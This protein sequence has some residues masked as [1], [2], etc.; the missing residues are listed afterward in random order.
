MSWRNVVWLILFVC[1]GISCCSLLVVAQED[2]PGFDSFRDGVNPALETPKPVAPPRPK[3]AA[4]KLSEEPVVTEAEF[5]RRLDQVVSVDFEELELKEVVRQFEEFLHISFHIDPVGL[6]ESGVTLDQILSLKLKNVTVHRALERS[7]KPLHL[8]YL[9]RD[10]IVEI[11]SFE[12]AS[13][14]LVTKLYDVRDVLELVDLNQIRGGIG[15]ISGGAGFGNG[16]SGGNHADES[17]PVVNAAQGAENSLPRMGYDFDG[18]IDVITSS[19]QA[20][21]WLDNGGKGTIHGYRHLLVV[22]Q[23][24]EYH[25]ELAT[26]LAEMKQ[27]LKPNSVPASK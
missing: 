18:L 3:V 7:L 15:R 27:M 26:L 24:Q 5:E 6:D 12:K 2:S 19:I 13:E 16:A 1:A 10:G 11:T 17:A 14:T 22:S 25:R 9:L 4:I 21:T 23:T 20:D 8:E